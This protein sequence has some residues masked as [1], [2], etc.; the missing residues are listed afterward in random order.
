[1]SAVPP[2]KTFRRVEVSSES[3]ES[4]HSREP[5]AAGP[6]NRVGLR[7]LCR[8]PGSPDQA[9][10]CAGARSGHK[11]N[12]MDGWA[13][14][15]LRAHGCP[16]N[17]APQGHQYPE[18]QEGQRVWPVLNAEFNACSTLKF[19]HQVG[20]SQVNFPSVHLGLLQYW[21]KRR[22]VKKMLL[23]HSS[24]QERTVL[25]PNSRVPPFLEGGEVPS[26]TFFTAPL[27]PMLPTPAA[28]RAIS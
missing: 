27:S 22:D 1:M 13:P 15:L 12:Q 2:I 9:G 7:D 20:A 24:L 3:Q 26:T 19:P 18:G 4:H 6:A 23:L 5:K 28:L 25:W 14:L 11:G 16:G 8:P 17:G 10:S 21:P